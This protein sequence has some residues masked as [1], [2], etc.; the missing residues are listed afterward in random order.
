MDIFSSQVTFDVSGIART[1]LMV[2]LTIASS[3]PTS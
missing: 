1:V 3:A 2:A